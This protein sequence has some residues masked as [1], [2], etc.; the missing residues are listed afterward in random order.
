VYGEVNPQIVFCPNLKGFSISWIFSFIVKC[1]QQCPPLINCLLRRHQKF[2]IIFFTIFLCLEMYCLQNLNG[3]ILMIPEIK[4]VNKS[5]THNFRKKQKCW[6]IVQLL[7]NDPHTLMHFP[8]MPIDPNELSIFSF[9]EREWERKIS[10]LSWELFSAS[11]QINKQSV[12]FSG[13][14]NQMNP[15]V[16]T[17]RKTFYWI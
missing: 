10:H 3:V 9:H 12:V 15:S 1:T 5:Y 4:N 16:L 7:W 2:W 14:K 8:K 11:F 6:W 17:Q 13:P